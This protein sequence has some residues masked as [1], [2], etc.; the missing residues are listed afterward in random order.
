MNR[1]SLYVLTFFGVVFSSVK[2]MLIFALRLCCA[3]LYLSSSLTF[4]LIAVLKS[5]C[6]LSWIILDMVKNF[7]SVSLS[8]ASM[9]YKSHS[10]KMCSSASF[11]NLSW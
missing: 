2:Q 5:C 8:G 7:S 9:R 3:R 1:E 10:F 11:L 6:S 4:P